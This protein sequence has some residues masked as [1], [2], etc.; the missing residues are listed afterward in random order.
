M[1]AASIKS[2]I[3]TLLAAA[4]GLAAR[5]AGGKGN[6]H[7]LGIPLK[8]K[9]NPR[10]R[11]ITILFAAFSL[12]SACA[13][14]N[15]SDSPTFTEPDPETYVSLMPPIL[16]Y[17]YHRKEAVLSGD[18]QAFYRRYPDLEHNTNFEKGI[19]TES[20]LI[21]S[22]H[23]LAPFDG[24]IH[25]EYYEKIKISQ[26]ENG[27]RVLVHGMELYLLKNSQGKFGESG[28]EFKLVLFMRQEGDTW[29]V[30][31]TD[32]VTLQEWQDFKP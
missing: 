4:L 1:K 15:R 17:F 21:S 20:T 8:R 25:P 32:E 16:E 11:I 19:N 6:I 5:F 10:L 27:I 23:A 28:G 22:Y 14:S 7:V 9:M 26:S 13:P 30:Y 3:G 24:N 18:L 29:Q 31:Q 12:L 2:L